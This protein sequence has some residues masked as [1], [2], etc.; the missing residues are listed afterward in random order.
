MHKIV[1][2][3]NGLEIIEIS[4]YEATAKIAL[5][6][7]H[8]F[9]YARHGQPELLWLSPTARFE[10][11]RAIRGG[12]PVCWP[13]FGMDP[14]IPERPQHGFARS[15]LWRLESVEES[16]ETGST[17]VTLMLD[18][19][20]LEQ[21]E[22]RWFPY[23]FELTMRI[24]IGEQLELA[25]TTK[26]LGE[27]PFEI[28]EAL[29]TY[30]SVGNIAAVS[31]VG[32]EGI[33][34]ADALDGFA[35]K[36]SSAPIGIT[37]ET[38]R[39]YL[40]TEDTVILLDERLGRTVIVGKSGSS[41]TVVWNPWIDKAARMEDF[42]DDGYTSMVCIETANALSNSVVIAPGDSHTITQSVK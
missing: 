2:A 34:Y 35:R 14:D 33:T 15:V 1:T 42:A 40:D 26:N 27:E 38:D 39:V 36:A 11:G 4:N 9:E 30:F 7:A 37:R 8:L 5:Q 28:T 21:H 41:S 10:P 12:V 24:T 16:D 32:L 18:D 29:H 22:R 23:L 25:L 31:I 6:G 20:M 13:W 19:T 17:I 3:E